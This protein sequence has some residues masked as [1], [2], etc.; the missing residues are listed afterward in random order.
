MPPRLERLLTRCLERD[1]RRRARDIGDVRVELDELLAPPAA[2]AGTAPALSPALARRV[3][4]WGGA[5]VVA[6]VAGGL[7]VWSTRMAITPPPGI[8]RLAIP[9]ALG[10][11]L[12]TGTA[13]LAMSP[14]GRYVAYHA[15]RAGR[16]VLYLRALAELD[17]REIS[18]D[19]AGY[20]FFSPGSDWLGFFSDG[21]LKK[22]PVRGGPAVTLADASG[23]RGAS[24][25]DVAEA[26][27][28][29]TEAI[30]RAKRK[31]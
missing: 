9:L 6:A 28:L 29:I 2:V 25:G 26:H 8:T 19:A 15:S 21:K 13:P 1:P 31:K 27:R 16:R 4:A 11:L 18:D 5:L 23:G 17:A 22:A 12:A 14:D 20:P 3:L 30:E 7:I 10:E 24:W